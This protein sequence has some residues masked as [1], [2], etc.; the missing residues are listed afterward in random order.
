VVLA[1][2]DLRLD[3]RGKPDARE[4]TE[5]RRHAAEGG[6]LIAP[7]RPWL[8]HWASAVTQHHEQWDGKGYP[9]GV[10]GLQISLGA[11][12]VAVADAF[13]TMTAT[14]TSAAAARAEHPAAIE[15]LIPKAG[16][17]LFTAQG[18]GGCHKFQPA[19]SNGNVGPDLDK[20]AQYAKAANQGSLQEFTHESIANPSAYIEKG[21]PPS[22]PNF[23]QTLSDQQIAD[24]VAY[25][26]QKQG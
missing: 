20:L 13:E 9:G 2:K 16:A 26:T 10:A 21:Y 5:L 15:A 8:G 3:Q 25:L 6:K 1:M 23:G 19:G 7:L 12:V 14:G 4:W 11:R 18:C 22:M 24:L 17:T